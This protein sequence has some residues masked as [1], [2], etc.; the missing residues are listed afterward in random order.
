MQVLIIHTQLW[1]LVSEWYFDQAKIVPL[2]SGS[3][4]A[5]AILFPVIQSAAEP[6]GMFVPLIPHTTLEDNWS[7]H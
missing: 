4:C 7:D 2:K 5:A 6:V 3:L 1:L